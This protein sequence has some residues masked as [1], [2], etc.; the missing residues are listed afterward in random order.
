M[1]NWYTKV[2]D[3]KGG[4]GYEVNEGG[5]FLTRETLAK[6]PFPGVRR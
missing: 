5:R 4:H 2:R 1:I 6:D 3:V